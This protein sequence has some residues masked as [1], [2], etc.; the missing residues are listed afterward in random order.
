[1][2]KSRSPW[3]SR[4]PGLPVSRSPGLSVPQYL[5]LSVSHLMLGREAWPA[6]AGVSRREQAQAGLLAH[7]RPGRIRAIRTRA[8]AGRARAS[9]EQEKPKRAGLPERDTGPGR[10]QGTYA[11]A[12][13]NLCEQDAGRREQGDFP[14]TLSDFWMT[15]RLPG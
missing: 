10:E 4:S 6:W 8:G 3:V 14:R 9:G 12:R 13:E 1:M 11:R 5:G 2:P 15:G 7:A